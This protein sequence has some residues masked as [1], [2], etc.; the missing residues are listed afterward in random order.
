VSIVADVMMQ[1]RANHNNS[2]KGLKAAEVA[3]HDAI[4][5]DRRSIINAL[6]NDKLVEQNE[7]IKHELILELYKPWR[8]DKFLKNNNDVDMYLNY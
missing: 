8:I 4:L 2:W 5:Q 1:V 3:L 7:K 6:R